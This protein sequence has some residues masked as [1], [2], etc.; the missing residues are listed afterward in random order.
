[1]TWEWVLFGFGAFMVLVV[2]WDA[3]RYR[4]ATKQVMDLLRK[5]GPLT[6]LELSQK[7]IPRSHVYLI[8]NRLE[9]DALIVS[10]QPR[11]PVY[12]SQKA[13]RVK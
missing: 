3:W 10:C 6:G 8:L 5:D 1:M 13:W 12:G 11:H 2:L 9:Q 4:R 7:G